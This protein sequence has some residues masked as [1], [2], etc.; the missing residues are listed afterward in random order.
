MMYVSWRYDDS[1]VRVDKSLYVSV[2]VELGGVVAPRPD[3]P[4][5]LGGQVGRPQWARQDDLLQAV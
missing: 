3:E 2:S 4:H 5:W 1:L